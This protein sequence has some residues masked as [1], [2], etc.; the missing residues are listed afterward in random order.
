MEGAQG[1]RRLVLVG[2]RLGALLALDAARAMPDAERI[3]LWQPV[4]TGDAMMTQFLRMDVAAQMLVQAEA[5]ARASTESMRQRLRRG[6]PIEVAGY[7]LAP[8]LVS[9]VEALRL[10]SLLPDHVSRIDWIEVAADPTRGETPA[11]NRV[12]QAWLA[13]GRPVGHRMVK[14]AP[15]WSSVEIVEV[16]QLVHETRIFWITTGSSMQ[17]ITFTTPPHSR[18]VS[19][20]MLNTRF[21]RCAQ[22][23]AMDGMYAGFAGAKTGHRGASFGR[24]LVLR[25][26]GRFELAA[27]TPPGGRHQRTMFT[28]GRKHAMKAGEIDA[29][30]WY[31]CGEASDKIQW[32][33]YHM[34]G[35]V[36]VRRLQL[37]AN[38]AIGR[39]RQ[40]LLGHGRP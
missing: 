22:V 35:A 30:L 11:G 25:H 21:R 36:P 10:E 31:Q 6:E 27:F 4:I 28:V 34:R 8:A 5:E 1:H 33:E 16:P 17:A 3:A 14:G 15:F 37:V 19:I 24:R 40:P 7:T 13:R 26:V 32:L 9:A 18:Q 12:R 29:W 23:N 39:Q 2:L 20:S 38:V